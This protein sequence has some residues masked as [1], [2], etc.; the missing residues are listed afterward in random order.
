V[1][2]VDESLERALYL[3]IYLCKKCHADG[4]LF[5]LMSRILNEI[6]SD[7]QHVFKGRAWILQLAQFEGTRTAPIRIAKDEVVAVHGRMTSNDI[8]TEEQVS[9]S[10]YEIP[11][12]GVC[13]AHFH[14]VFSRTHPTYHSGFSGVSHFPS[15]HFFSDQTFP[16]L[17]PKD[18]VSQFHSSSNR[19]DIVVGRLRHCTKEVVVNEHVVTVKASDLF[20]PI[21]HLAQAFPSLV[22]KDAIL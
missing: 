13:V 3:C 19:V 1:D 4:Q 20:P 8:D 7:F 2:E 14:L 11:V 12:G 21:S 18:R 17:R 5:E 9:L 16:C 6:L 10:A 22:F 15:I